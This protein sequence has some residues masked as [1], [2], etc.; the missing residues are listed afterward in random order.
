MSSTANSPKA[1]APFQ[2]PE[3]KSPTAKILP[4][5]YEEDLKQRQQKYLDWEQKNPGTVIYEIEKLEMR[6]QRLNKKRGWSA[7]DVAEAN[8]IDKRIQELQKMLKDLYIIN[9]DITIE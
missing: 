1:R 3:P 7:F 8:L 6:R 5:I 9:E 2:E 4:T